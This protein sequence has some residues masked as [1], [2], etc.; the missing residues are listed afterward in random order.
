MTMGWSLQLC[1]PKGIETEQ[2][3]YTRQYL[4]LNISCHE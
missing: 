4:Q 2:L 1:S 3:S